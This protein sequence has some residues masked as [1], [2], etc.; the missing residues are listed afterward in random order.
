MNL[1]LASCQYTGCYLSAEAMSE[2]LMIVALSPADLMKK[3]GYT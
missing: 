3:A 2:G 1:Y